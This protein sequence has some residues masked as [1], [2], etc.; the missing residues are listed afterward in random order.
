MTKSGVHTTM[1]DLFLKISLCCLVPFEVLVLMD[2]ILR[3][4]VVN[5][6]WVLGCTRDCAFHLLCSPCYQV[7]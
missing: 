5:S 1:W 3:T 2:N 4:D 6:C 7:S